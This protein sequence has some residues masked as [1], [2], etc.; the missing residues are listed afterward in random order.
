M[1][2]PEQERGGG[3]GEGGSDRPD[4]HHA[5]HHVQHTGRRRRQQDSDG[6]DEVGE[7]NHGGNNGNN[8]GKHGNHGGNHGGNNGGNNGGNGDGD[9]DVDDS[10]RESGSDTD[11]DD[12]CRRDEK[13]SLTVMSFLPKVYGRNNRL[14]LHAE[15]QDDD[16]RAEDSVVNSLFT[17]YSEWHNFVIF[18]VHL[19]VVFAEWRNFGIFLCTFCRSFCRNCTMLYMVHSK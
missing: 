2:Q 12:I 5:H 4:A 14:R 10:E 3:G 11:Y 7:S 17:L 16:G 18:C 1:D 13:R 8:G 15:Y 9:S 6:Y 19:V